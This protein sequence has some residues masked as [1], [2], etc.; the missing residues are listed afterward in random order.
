M[1]PRNKEGQESRVKS[2]EPDDFG[3]A[4]CD[5]RVSRESR[6]VAQESRV[7]SQE[8]R[9]RGDVRCT[10]LGPRS[11]L[12]APRSSDRRGVLL[13]VVLGM[14]VLFMLIGTAWIMVS[15]QSRTQAI[16]AAKVNR[17][18]NKP[19]ELLDR[20]LREWLRDTNRPNSVIRYHSLLRDL[21]GTDGFQGVI[22]SPKEDLAFNTVV[23]AQQVTRFA[24]A[25]AGTPAQQLGP[26]QG[27]MI[28][29]YVSA[30]DYSTADGLDLRHVLELERNPGGQPEVQ[31]LPL[32]RGYFNGCLLTVTSG[33]ATGQTTRIVDYEYVGD[34]TTTA[35]NPVRPHRLYRLRVLAF[36]RSDGQPLSIDQT[37]GRVPELSDLAGA[38]FLVN[39]RAFNGTGLGYNP[40]A[41]ASQP[42]LT[43]LELFQ[44][45]SNY[46]GTELALT[47]NYAFLDLLKLAA[48]D[49]TVAPPN[50]FAS[51]L[52]AQNFFLFNKAQGREPLV[53]TLGPGD[54]DESYDAADFQNM[55]LALV[56]AT[57]RAT[58]RV[59]Q[60]DSGGPV[61]TEIDD[62][63]VVNAQGAYVNADRFLRLDLENVPWPSFHRPDLVN[64]WYHRMLL[65]ISDGKPTDAHVRAILQPFQ[66]DGAPTQPLSL[67][68]AALVAAIKRK[69]ML[70]PIRED[71]PNFDGGNPRSVP[72]DLA[73]TQQLLV[74][75]N[76]AI[77]YWEA[78]G[79]WD[80]DNDNDGVPDSVWVDLGDPVLELED[81]TRYKPLYAYLIVDLDSRLNVNAHGLADHINPPALARE[82]LANGNFVHVDNLAGTNAATKYSTDLLAEGLGFGPAE[83]SLRPVFPVPWADATGT[84]DTRAIRVE[85]YP[86]TEPIDSY[87]TL[88]RGRERLD[89]SAVSGR[90]GYE[91]SALTQQGRSAVSP[92]LNYTF[93]AN[94]TTPTGEQAVPDLAAQLKLFD[95]PWAI[96]QRSAYGTPPDLFGRYGVGLDPTGQPVYEVLA[97]RNAE[98]T[99]LARPLLTDSPYEVDLS[100]RQRRDTWS[101]S[102]SN[103]ATAFNASLVQNDD[104]PFATADLE[105]VLRAFDADAGTLPS[106]LWDVVDVFD[107]VKLM[108]YD[109]YRTASVANDLFDPTSRS[110]APNDPN[111]EP[112]LLTAAQ[113]M[114]AISRRLVTTDSADLPVAAG[115]VPNQAVLALG[116][117]GAPGRLGA[118]DN[119]AGGTD[120]AT[121]LN[122][123]NSDDFRSLFGKDVSQATIVDLLRYR[124]W[125][126]V[127]AQ[128]MRENSWDEAALAKQ[129]AGNYVKFL[130]LVSQRAEAVFRGESFN[131][132]N[133]N[134]VYDAG[135]SFQANSQDTNGN[136]MYD[137]P[138]EQL[139]APEI[140][141][142]IRMDLNR[143]FGD[144]VDNNGN[145]VVDDPFEAGEPFL[146]A[147]V[148]GRW[149]QGEKWLDI[150]T[151]RNYDGPRD[152]LWA[153]LTST[154]GPITEPITF[155]YTNGH[156]GA[157]HGGLAAAAGNQV[158]AGA[159]VRNLSSQARQL[160]ARHLYCLM[161]LMMDENYIAPHDEN[162]PQTKQFLDITAAN[163]TGKAIR[164]ALAA[165]GHPTP[166]QEA[167]RILLRKLTCRMIA[168]WAVNCVD[169]RDAD[170]IM[171]PFEYDENPWDGWGVPD[172][173]MAGNVAKPVN[174]PLDGDPATDENLGQAIDWSAVDVRNPAMI[175]PIATVAAP[176]T[177]LNQTRGLVWGA[178]RP[179]LLI[180]E[181]L[182]T[183]DRRTEDL[184]SDFTKQQLE[185]GNPLKDDDLDQ[186]LRP[187][188][189]AFFEIYNPWSPTGQYPAELYS[190]L[191]RDPQNRNTIPVGLAPSP[192]IELGRLSTLGIDATVGGLSDRIDPTTQTTASVKRS[193]VWR[194]VV[195]EEH[196][197]YRNDDRFDDNGSFVHQ[198][199][200]AARYSNRAPA[201]FEAADPDGVGFESQAVTPNE[202]YIERSIYFTTDNSDRFARG[203][204]PALA[205]Y[206]DGRNAK[207]LQVKKPDDKLRI[208]P[209]IVAGNVPQSARY[210]IAGDVRNA[211]DRTRNEDLDVPIAPIMPGRYALV[212]TAGAQYTDS[213]TGQAIDGPVQAVDANGNLQTDQSFSPRYV[214]TVS[215]SFV[216]DNTQTTDARHISGLDKT[217]RIELRPHP[218]P[219]FQQ[220]LVAGNGG[221][222]LF[223]NRTTTGGR[224]R[225][226]APV[227]RDNELVKLPP[228]AAP[229]NGATHP[230]YNIYDGNNDGIPDTEL[231][232][233]I[234]AVP[235][236]NMSL[237]EPL[238]L[239]EAR[240]KVLKDEETQRPA[241][242]G[243]N[244]TQISHYWDPL[245]ANGEG[246]YTTNVA[247]GGAEGPYDM[248]F[249]EAPEL[250]RNGTTRNYRT[251]H[252]QRL[253]DPT[254]PWNPLPTMVDRNGNTIPNPQHD[255]K[256]PVNLYRTID[257]AS[258]D[259]T[260]YNGTSRREPDLAPA[261]VRDEAKSLPNNPQATSP[262]SFD[263]V[264]GFLGRGAQARQHRLS[265]RSLERG[266]HATD[267]TTAG[268]LLLAPRLM[269]RQEP[270]MRFDPAD[271]FN[272]PKTNDMLEWHTLTTDA[273]RRTWLMKRANDLRIRDVGSV[274]AEGELLKDIA[275][276]ASTG[277]DGDFNRF[278]DELKPRPAHF[279]IVFDHSLGFQNEAFGALAT[280]ADVQQQGLSAAARGAPL[281]DSGFSRAALDPNNPNQPPPVSATY[282]WFAWGN[283]PFVSAEELLNV[284]A[285]SSSQMLRQ[286]AALSN[287]VNNIPNPYN[288]TGTD[289]TG[290]PLTTAARL[291]LLQAPF[292]HLLNFFA[293][294]TA[295]AGAIPPAGTATEPSYVGAP[296][297]YRV[298]EY[299]QVP[300][301][302]VATDTLFT[303]EIFSDQP[304]VADSAVTGGN[305]TGPADPRYNF[306]PPFNKVSRQRDPGR[307]NLN[308]V[309]GHREL[310]SGGVPQ[311]WSEVFDGIMHRTQDGNL[312]NAAGTPT[313]LGHLG[314]AWRDVVLSRKG[315]AQFNAD[316]S[317]APVEKMSNSA[318]PDVFAFGLNP[319]FPSVISNP[320]RSPD[321][322][323]LV[324]LPQMVHYGVDASWLRG[325]HFNRGPG[326]W[327]RPGDDNNDGS[328]DDTREAGFGGDRFSYNTSTGALLP[329][330]SST[331][332]GIYPLFSESFTAPYV[333]GERNSYF[334]YHPLSRLGNLV[335]NRSN[336][337]AV[338]ITVG[339]FEVEKAPNWND[340]DATVRAT[341]QAHF[342]NDITLYNR[343]YPDGYMLGREVG[344][345]TGNIRRQRGF[346]IIDRTEPVGFKPGED[347]NVE[348]MIR[349]R[350]RIE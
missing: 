218:N 278:P 267:K 124:V 4:A 42:R 159:Q 17:K 324:P 78:V 143:P 227:Q 270:P 50:A 82:Q 306:Q 154:A 214:T 313:Q 101:A 333:D 34:L 217:R 320:F 139:L 251:V 337:F 127:R 93:V 156:G 16:N 3:L 126:Q 206:A 74:N 178:E 186:R 24:G 149:D 201:F 121:E 29:V 220:V 97:D 115:T 123:P 229:L 100:S 303:A 284:P 176:P 276:A 40:L 151:N 282:P 72:R 350:R 158:P 166:D 174:L 198:G 86:A 91:P 11:S 204:A 342:N 99:S 305:I 79:P 307:V 275:A 150:F 157:V 153:N 164:D 68:Q 22:Y 335:T 338:W 76:I 107:P 147:N 290:A 92:G 244:Y 299:V 184:G 112:Q 252:L 310:G 285:A 315:Y 257:T 105:R 169:M 130:A 258:V 216:G 231:I 37:A 330:V 61:F 47:P 202:P 263:K 287:D 140:V 187:K 247:G 57:P 103:Q 203:E 271:D 194:M 205:N 108:T 90:Y 49:P 27:Q 238:D 5:A 152:Q 279:D 188:G 340:P 1:S 145:G 46:I 304:G 221:T 59:V 120:D 94:N 96:T 134:G 336:V 327:G 183:H 15:S 9:A 168:Q 160:Y 215:R 62:P 224:P 344:T 7:E 161:L 189:S 73:N 248:P 58:G 292:G 233:P 199:R 144:G 329:V 67:Q 208:P 323:D 289:A 339:Y 236:A 296:H 21:Y 226:P 85:T 332:R 80:V 283:R 347:L 295:P 240:R 55:W 210:F 334:Y 294:A 232:S 228:G 318:P 28:D 20:A 245:A 242:P 45:G 88:L 213:T 167:R 75:N 162:D 249:D 60:D 309:T 141:A 331:D 321:A 132:R 222:P 269:W 63:R 87:A 300:S 255:P 77:P 328:V 311:I 23:P 70:R 195:V 131:D 196:P 179:E 98:N 10:L 138:L 308:T 209:E 25:T 117:D 348:S 31:T 207:M 52:T 253:A 26:T 18:G 239:Y 234:V 36:A 122:S 65:L 54:A 83:I 44:I 128:V 104:A 102:F 291:A 223:P 260:T 13:L 241:P 30:L 314:P 230:F 262:Y 116:A 286:F 56:T 133:G 181:S 266:L 225:D 39:G 14:L 172:G 43:A 33:A 12:L 259:L 64:Y 95:Y 272:D 265:F 177:A 110:I 193:P 41:A 114:A 298:L 212:A 180:T 246:M 325:H 345:D 142:G 66:P 280:S 261:R 148:N 48:L 155:D 173:T 243:T 346:Y 84:P 106:R 273:D 200:P 343:V 129:N 197:E 182:A 281:L 35:T 118:D 2:R 51:N 317:A 125:T 235:V 175:K 219:E 163:S 119:G 237:S 268:D 71:H 274:G 165:A 53:Y 301:R 89:L 277:L 146:D 191:R 38:T 137:P 254:L 312:R 293:T 341:V 171:T 319:N 8:S 111:D 19:G 297:F 316:G 185:A 135:D 264:Y 81:G 69:I 211:L 256:L 288:G 136:G 349:L 32:S 109:P 190:Q 113:Q 192:G 322:G 250:R 326:A 302:Y 170:A 6:A